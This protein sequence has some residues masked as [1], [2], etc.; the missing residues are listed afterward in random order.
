MSNAPDAVAFGGKTFTF[1]GVQSFTCLG[2]T[3][4]CE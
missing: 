1:A 2:V 3:H 4:T